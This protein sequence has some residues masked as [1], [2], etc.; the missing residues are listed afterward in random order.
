MTGLALAVGYLMK[1]FH[2]FSIVTKV[3]KKIFS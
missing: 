2:F 1:K 3:I